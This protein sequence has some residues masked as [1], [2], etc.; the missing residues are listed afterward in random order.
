[1]V[2]VDTLLINYIDTYTPVIVAKK[3]LNHPHVGLEEI[4]NNHTKK[5]VMHQ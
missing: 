2:I 3:L 5:T 1:M 4:Q